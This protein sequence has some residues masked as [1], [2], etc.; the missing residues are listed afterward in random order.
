M[1][2]FLF[3]NLSVK[4]GVTTIVNFKDIFFQYL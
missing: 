3:P 2:E 4:L 1:V